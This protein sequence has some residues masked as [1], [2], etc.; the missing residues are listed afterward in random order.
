M[1]PK[2]ACFLATVPATPCLVLDL[3]IVEA[4]YRAMRAAL[5]TAHIYY[6]VKANPA[7][8]IL[9]RLAALG[10]H[11]DAASG[12]EIALCLAAG[13]TSD[14]ISFGNTI[15]K[16]AA[17][18]QAREAGIDL[19]V[20]DCEA[21]LQKIAANAPG[22]RVFCRLAVGATGAVLP[23][24]R[25]FGTEPAIATDL[26][27]AAKQHGLIPYGLSFHVGSQQISVAAYE[28]AIAQTAALFAALARAGIALSMIDIGGG[29][30]TSYQEPAPAIQTFAERITASLAAHF[31]DR[32]PT[33]IVEPGR[34]LV[35][36][37]GV[38]SSEVLLVSHRVKD[39]PTR[40]VYLDIGRFGG[41][42]ETENEAI[43][44]RI[45][46][47][48]DGPAGDGTAEGPVA[49]AGPSCDSTDILY[50]K[51]GYHLPLALAPGDRIVIHAAGAYVTT[52]ASTGFNGFPPLE[53]HYL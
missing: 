5:P 51:S 25:K 33:L 45:T 30:P 36:N 11:F 12:E 24:A 42:A 2:I 21:E 26:M 43:R 48:H 27:Q 44:Y 47:P 32:Q 13:A 7:R 20:F 34:F 15:K 31:G 4:N 1:T 39:D 23:L 9:E 41:L 18:R 40:W 19:F 17:I 22:A 52:Y 14:R 53:E 49:I 29:F 37:A 8:P 35:G 16:P 50:E 38:I 6:A 3:D 28:A 10:S 46:T